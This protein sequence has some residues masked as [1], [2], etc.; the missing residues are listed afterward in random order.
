MADSI[1]EK[2]PKGPNFLLIVILSGVAILLILGIALF[3]VKR[4]GPKMAP[5]GPNP[6]PNSRLVYPGAQQLPAEKL[7]A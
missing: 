4:E 1:Y 2:S 5:H 7:A 6:A 3:L